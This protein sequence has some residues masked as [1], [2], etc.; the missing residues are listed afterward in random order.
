MPT[1]V[2]LVGLAGPVLAGEIYHWVDG[3]G[4]QHFSQVAPAGAVKDV[5]T[6]KLEE[7]APPDDAAEAD[8][9]HVEAQ[10][11]RMQAL[12]DEMD[13]RREERRER[14]REAAARPPAPTY[15]EPVRYAA[16]WWWNRPGNPV[17]RPPPRPQPPPKPEPRPSATFKPPGE[18]PG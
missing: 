9:Y 10:A 7:P 12:R 15:Q 8:I 14:Q 4:V 5:T 16:P 13:R 17:P 3:N 18:G 6:L 2:L 11:E 1:A